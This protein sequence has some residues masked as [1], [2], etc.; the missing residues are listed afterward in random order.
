M[1]LKIKKLKNK[2]FY[3]SE[4]NNFIDSLVL[5]KISKHD[6]LNESFKKNVFDT[7][8]DIFGHGG[9]HEWGEYVVCSICKKVQDIEKTHRLSGYVHISDLPNELPQSICCNAPVE[10]FHRKDYLHKKFDSLLNED[11]IIMY[12]LKDIKLNRIVGLIIGFISPVEIVWNKYIKDKLILINPANLDKSFLKER[13]IYIDEIGVIKSHRHG[14][15]PFFTLFSSLLGDVKKSGG[16]KKILFWTHKG[17][18]LYNI[19]QQVSHSIVV[20]DIQS[21]SRVVVSVSFPMVYRM[22]KF[23]TMI[24]T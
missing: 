16:V 10:Y 22:V 3:S 14:R 17:S 18:R 19:T 11:N 9:D 21:P 13:V 4:Y 8:R 5:I 1:N 6:F 7:Y 20:E 15:F 2:L 24:Y 12:V 23:V